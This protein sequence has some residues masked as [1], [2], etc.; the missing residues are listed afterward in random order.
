MVGRV[1]PE[2]WDLFLSIEFVA[3][4]LIGGAGTVAGVLMGT[5]F[6]IMTPRI[7]EEVTNWLA[8]QATEGGLFSWL[9]NLFIRSSPDDYIGI[10]SLDAYGPGL[11]IFQ[12]NVVLFGVLIVVFLIVEP[13][14]LYGIWIRVR[15]YWK[16][17]PFTY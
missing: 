13:L 1:I 16:G 15:N 10:I 17:W 4:V 14:G 5:L 6:V 9:G 2:T 12:L 8:N 3:I 7:V 11:S